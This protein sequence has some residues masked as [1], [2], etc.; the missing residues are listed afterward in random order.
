MFLGALQMFHGNPTF[1]SLKDS[2]LVHHSICLMDQITTCFWWFNMFLATEADMLLQ[3]EPGRNLKGDT[4]HLSSGMPSVRLRHLKTSDPDT[5]MKLTRR[6][7]HEGDWAPQ[8]QMSSRLN[9]VKALMSCSTQL[10][11][12]HP[13]PIIFSLDIIKIK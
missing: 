13:A 1:G 11:Q 7:S 8:I 4:S 5:K 10:W 6:D 2:F 3:T 9:P 12:T